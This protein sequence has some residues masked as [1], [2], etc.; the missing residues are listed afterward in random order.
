METKDSCIQQ[1]ELMLTAIDFFTQRFHIEQL[2]SYAF[3]IS[4][5][6]YDFKASALFVKE[7]NHFVLREQKEYTKLLYQIESNTKLEELPIYHG[8]VLTTEI[9]QYFHKDDIL[10]FDMKFVLPLINDTELLG[11]ILSNGIKGREF[12]Q[13]DLKF[14]DALMRLINHSLENNQRFLDY[15]KINTELDRKIFDLLVVNQ[16]TKALLSELTLDSLYSI[17]TDVFSEVSGSKVTSFGIYDALTQ[18]VKMTGYRNVNSFN[19]YYTEFELLQTEYKSSNIVLHIEN[20][21][22]ILKKIFKNYEEFSRLEAKYVIL[23]VKKEIIGVV[24][25]SDSITGEPYGKTEIELIES[26]ASTT[27][28]GITNARLFEEITREKEN[29]EKKYG[30]LST[31]NRLVTTITSCKSK[32]EL[33]ELTLQTLQL[34]Y[35]VKKAFICERESD[36]MYKVQHS[37]GVPN[38]VDKGIKFKSIIE[39]EAAADT[40]YQFTSPNIDEFIENEYFLDGIDDMNC[41]VFSPI[42]VVSHLESG[43]FKNIL[44]YIVVLET[45]D[46]LKEEEVL[47]ID[48]IAKNISPVI[49]QMEKVS[50]NES[51]NATNDKTEFIAELQEKFE[52]ANLFDMSFNVYIKEIKKSPF[53]E[54]VIEDIELNLSGTDKLYVI[55]NYLFVISYEDE[56]Q[57]SWIKVE[58]PENLTQ[59]TIEPFQ[60]IS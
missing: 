27:Y 3:D 41:I 26:L 9:D 15:N 13:N 42:S 5:Q 56:K 12:T 52:E 4:N 17:A 18:R 31:L 44:G 22:D 39:H 38:I 54:I 51:M 7:G 59:V 25:I 21:Q 8:S 37:I 48:T 2:L 32:E 57:G 58:S 14:S 45:K 43:G 36:Q 29:T 28:I 34:G 40:F 49:Y 1:Y 35:G 53:E 11:F 46:N 30:V 60:K 55:D 20:D 10:T 47:L 19:H 50:S 24:T 23:I 6:L 16:S 33:Y